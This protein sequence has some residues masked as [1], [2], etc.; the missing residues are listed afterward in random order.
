MAERCG[1]AADAAVGADY[2]DVN[3]NEATLPH[4]YVKINESLA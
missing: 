1:R 2:L 3:R 4:L